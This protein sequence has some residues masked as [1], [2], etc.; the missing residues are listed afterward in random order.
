MTCNQ[1]DLFESIQIAYK[2]I[3]TRSTL[4]V[5]S[6][7]LI[8]SDNGRMVL[9]ATDLEMAVEHS[10]QVR[11]SKKGLIVVPAKLISD[12][13]RSLSEEA[14]NLSFD[15]NLNKL[16]LEG[17][18]A[19]F[20]LNT[21]PPEDFPQF[22]KIKEEEKVQIRVASF[23]EGAKQVLKAVSQDESRPIL[24]GVLVNIQKNKIKMVATDSYRLA[25]KELPREI[26]TKEEKTPPAPDQRKG[27]QEISL[28]VPGRTLEETLKI[29]SLLDQTK[30]I[31][32]GSSQKQVLFDLG[33]TKII[34]RVIQGN[35]PQYQRIFPEKFP[36]KIEVPREDFISATKRVSLFSSSTPFK[37]KITEN[38]IILSAESPEAGEAQEIVEGKVFGEDTE[39][40]FNPK[41]FLDGLT[42]LSS[43]EA[44]LEIAAPQKPSLI[45]SKKEDNFLYLIMP[46]RVS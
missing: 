29:V 43:Q 32:I 13:V 41:F 21:L 34:S 35:Y 24:A 5:L 1:K 37:I 22:P 25:V 42:S 12:V 15:K 31:K 9:Q 14:V 3:S 33:E 20:L 45:R 46:M 11:V 44:I 40:A 36:T 38:K 28:I 18:K 7:I 4:P 17:R 2:A 23:T 8:R 39:I 10:K 16:H 6:G 26:K 27:G 19:K 30:E